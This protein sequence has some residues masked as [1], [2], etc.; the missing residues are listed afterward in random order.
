T[1][2]AGAD[3]AAA[4]F[5]APSASASGLAA[6]ASPTADVVASGPDTAKQFDFSFGI[7]AGAPGSQGPAGPAGPPGQDSTVPGPQGDPGPPAFVG[8]SAPPNPDP[9]WVWFDSTTTPATMRFWNGSAWQVAQASYTIP[10]PLTLGQFVATNRIT[11]PVIYP[12]ASQA[13]L[14]VQVPSGVN[15]GRF[16]IRY[17]TDAAPQSE[18]DFQF[19]FVPGVLSRVR[20][21]AW[22]QIAPAP[23]APVTTG[24]PA[25]PGTSAG[26]MVAD[27]TGGIWVWDGNYWRPVGGQHYYAHVTQTV[28]QQIP[29][30]G[31]WTAVNWDHVVS[32]PHN[33]MSST[34]NRY[35]PPI[36]GRYSVFA[37]VQVAPA[38][39]A[40][41]RAN[42]IGEGVTE[43]IAGVRAVAPS[44]P[45]E[46]F[47][48]FGTFLV[49]GLTEP[50][51]INI[52]MSA[53]AA[54]NTNPITDGRVAAQFAYVGPV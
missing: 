33:S 8:S 37:T 45:L 17:N 49:M 20:N 5:D 43:T 6:G 15:A 41:I 40:Y 24:P 47:Q 32:D 27:T 34:G 3:G 52:E 42:A 12:P 54:V 25:A 51:Y 1:G 53:N 10:D 35:I 23:P 44:T 16:H 13:F 11:T 19:R 14:Q 50:L 21:G 48:V 28:T 18:G 22:E 4:G 30:T 26:Q 39:N 9:G 7:P 29:G 46:T 31:A 36:P 38:S 2:P